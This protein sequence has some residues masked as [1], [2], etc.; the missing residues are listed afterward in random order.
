MLWVTHWG[1]PGVYR[2]NPL[3]G[4]LIGKVGVPA[5]HVTSWAFAGDDLD[6]LIITT[7][8]QHLRAN[9][10][11]QYPGSGDVFVGKTNVK[12]VKQFMCAI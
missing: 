6:H 7:A 3:N 9:E 10:L 12:G 2:W 11:L 8:R 1:G 5:P 4:K